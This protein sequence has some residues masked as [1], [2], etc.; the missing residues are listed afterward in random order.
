MRPRRL[1]S[2]VTVAAGVF[3]VVMT[4]GSPAAADYAGD[5]STGNQFGLQAVS[6]TVTG[7]E[8]DPVVTSSGSLTVHVPPTCWW[9]PFN[10]ENMSYADGIED[11]TAPGA[12]AKYIDWLAKAQHSYSLFSRLGHPSKEDMQRVADAER[13]GT[14]YTWYSLHSAEGVNCAD[15]GFVPSGGQG[16]EG[17]GAVPLAYRAFPTGTPPDPPLVDVEDVV[18]MVWDQAAAE[19]AGPALDRNPKIDAAGGST[20]VNLA[21]WFWV[22]NVQEALASDG[23]IHLE[24]SI[25]GTPVQATLD[26][27]TEGVQVTSPAGATECSVRAA[28][29]EWSPSA[30]EDSACTLAFNRANRAGW[31]V[32]A[33]TTWTGSWTGTDHNGS[34]S[35]E[36][37]ALTP[38]ASIVVPVAESQALVDDVG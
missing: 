19:V 17:V 21:T 33:Q 8:G 13:S 30:S 14:D 32:T 7:G 2:G 35:G 20:L 22:Q 38:S 6:V 36:L 26:A 37:E 9:E 29:T 1:F 12:M 3:V 11:P 4:V 23:K 18:E 31:T 24:V 10:L 15:E 27:A 25:P 34:T 5:D 16:P 28:K